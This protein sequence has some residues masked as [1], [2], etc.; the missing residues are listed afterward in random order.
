MIRKWIEI[1]DQSNSAQSS[2]KTFEFTTNILRLNVCDIRDSHIV[3]EI[4]ITVTTSNAAI[5][6]SYHSL[7][8]SSKKKDKSQASEGSEL[9]LTMPMYNLLS[10]LAIILK[11][12]VSYGSILRLRQ[13]LIMIFLLLELLQIQSF[14]HLKMILQEILMHMKLIMLK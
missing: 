3:V 14:S 12:Q 6:N 5:F 8:V 11:H 7:L 10:L 4:A 2:S 1:N 13:I 9:D